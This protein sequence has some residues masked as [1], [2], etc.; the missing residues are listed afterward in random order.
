MIPVL[1]AVEK[2]TRGVAWTI[3]QKLKTVLETT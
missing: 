1:V 2:N 3:K